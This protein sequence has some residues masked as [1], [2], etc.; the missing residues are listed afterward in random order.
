VERNDIE[1]VDDESAEEAQPPEEFDVYELV[2]LRRAE[3]PPYLDDEASELL[4]R[5]HLGHLAAMREK[6]YLKVAGPLDEQPDE[7]W[8]GIGL[9]QVGS[10][11]EAERLARED[12]AVK[13]GRLDVAVMHWYCAK[14][15]ITF[16]GD[17]S[18]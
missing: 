18:D 1:S 4:Q 16:P 6:G 3:N 17:R 15:A 8:R 11:A 10:L 12:P 2:L 5:R 13:A 9:Y 7:R 14:G